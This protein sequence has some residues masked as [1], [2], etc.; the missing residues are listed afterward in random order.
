MLRREGRQT[1]ADTEF[2]CIKLKNAR[3]PA[4]GL[5]AKLMRLKAA[6]TGYDIIVPGNELG[7]TVDFFVAECQKRM[8]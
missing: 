8:S 1:T 7:C 3:P 5:N 2:V 6:V 4:K